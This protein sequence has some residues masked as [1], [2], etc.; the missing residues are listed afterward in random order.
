MVTS[1]DPLDLR[2]GVSPDMSNVGLEREGVL[3][4]RR[5][6]ARVANYSAG[7]AITSMFAV[8]FA[9]A[10]VLMIQAGATLYY[11]TAIGPLWTE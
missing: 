2:P 4:A 10:P 5:G 11:D 9:V 1:A 6:L 8:D 7:A 3:H